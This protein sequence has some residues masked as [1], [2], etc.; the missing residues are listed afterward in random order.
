MEMLVFGGLI[1]LGW[2]VYWSATEIAAAIRKP[3]EY[4]IRFGEAGDE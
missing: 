3:R 2:A 1:F 4:T